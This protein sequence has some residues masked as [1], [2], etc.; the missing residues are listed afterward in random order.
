MFGKLLVAAVFLTFPHGS[1]PVLLLCSARAEEET[2]A[3]APESS[4]L[5]FC[6]CMVG[7]HRVT[8]PLGENLSSRNSPKS[9]GLAQ[10]CWKSDHVWVKI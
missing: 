5:L 3:T 9:Q 4:G 2:S 8:A 7:T 10:V 1:C 6:L